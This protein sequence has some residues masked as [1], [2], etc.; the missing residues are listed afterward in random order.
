VELPKQHVAKSVDITPGEIGRGCGGGCLGGLFASFIPALTP[1]VGGFL[2]GHA[3]GQTGDKP[4]AISYGTNR[5]VYYIGSIML[6]FLPGLHMRKGG[7][8][9]M[10]NLV[11]VPETAEQYYILAAG[12]AITGALS[13]LIMFLMSRVVIKFFMDMKYQ[14]FQIGVLVLLLFTVFIMA[15]WQ[16]LFI[17]SVSTAIGIIP[18]M[19]HSRRT[20]LLAVILVPIWLNIAGLGPMVAGWLGLL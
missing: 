9:I 13:V 10:V 16:G 19:F 3:T 14:N 15:G 1:G 4:F 20:N 6:F 12:I 17:M 5:V 2:A 8:S 7:V 18:V 11:F